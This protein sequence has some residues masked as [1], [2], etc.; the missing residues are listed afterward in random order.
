MSIIKVNRRSLG[1]NF[2]S[3]GEA[4]VLVWAPLAQQVT[5][6]NETS[7]ERIVLHA[8]PHGYF[9]CITAKLKP[10]DRYWVELDNAGKLPDPASLWQPEGIDGPSQVYAAGSFKWR[11]DQWANHP[12]KETIIYEL[13]VGTFTPQGTFTGVAGK[14]PYLKSLG[15]TAIELMPIAEFAGARNWGYDGVFPFAAHHAYGGPRALQEMVDACHQNGIAVILDVVY[16][17]LGPEGNNLD[18][19]G[20]YFTD[21]YK[22]PWGKAVNFDDAQSDEVRKYFLENALMWFRDF[23]IDGLRLDAV[24]AIRDFGATHFL[25]ELRARVDEL[26][27]ATGRSHFLIAECDLNDPKYLQDNS[28]NGYGMDAQWIDEF[29]HALRVASGRPPVGYYSDFKD[30]P[31]LAKAFKDAYVFDGQY[32]G[33]R[34]KTFGRSAAEFSADRFV[35][36][37]QNHDQ[38]GNTMLGERTSE[39]VTFE[40]LKLLAGAVLTSPY[41][42]LLFMGEEY[43]EKRPF[44]YFVSHQG[45]ELIKAVREGRKSEFSAFFDDNKEF[46]D[47]QSPDTF[48]RSK[49]NWDAMEDDQHGLLLAYY[50]E[51][52]RIR[53]NS[54]LLSSG[55]R[56]ELSVIA[57]DNE[58][59]LVI[60]RSVGDERMVSVF[61]FSEP[62]QN[63]Q[64]PAA[65]DMRCLVNSA[66]VRWGGIVS[67]MVEYRS[68]VNV[69]GCSFVLFGS[70]DV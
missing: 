37:S 25:Q 28:R 1:I 50:R 66:S 19:F 30:F 15:I 4:E 22:T 32:S 20:P 18:K 24:H 16:N 39:L 67:D 10:Y 52:I 31:S 60:D 9:S 70:N 49:L 68:Y 65:R 69:V 3:R 7:D 36:F 26:N 35:V 47:P 17:H 21:K 33:H 42:P 23:H 64:L 56:Q 43:G 29:H 13:H 51:L 59:C 55:N 8:E 63:V 62:L 46:P 40:M 14:I 58:R 38:V 27:D 11:E 45:E 61:N 53:R 57:L 34:Q 44:Q 2:S 6:V 5:I 54:P 48:L 12:L 41:I